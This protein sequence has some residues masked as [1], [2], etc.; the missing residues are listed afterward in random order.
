MR[1][2]KA[3]NQQTRA[4][5]M[6][7]TPSKRPIEDAPKEPMNPITSCHFNLSYESL[8]ASGVFTPGSPVSGTMGTGIRPT[9]DY[10]KELLKEKRKLEHTVKMSKIELEK[11]KLEI[12]AVQKKHSNEVGSLENRIKVSTRF[13]L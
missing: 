10:P 2:Y 13:C 6:Y 5:K 1:P 7:C 3:D 12:E 8:T 9:S 4:L 11:S